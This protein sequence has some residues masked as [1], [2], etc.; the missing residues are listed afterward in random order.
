VPLKELDRLLFGRERDPEDEP[1]GIYRQCIVG[2]CGDVPAK[3]LSAVNAAASVLLASAVESR[4][5]DAGIVA[6]MD[7][8]HPW[9]SRSILVDEA[10]NVHKH[11]RST[12]E[13]VPILDIL[14]HAV[15]EQG[16]EKI[17]IVGLP[18]QIQ[19]I[20]KMQQLGRPDGL[21]KAVALTI[22]T[23]CS[24]K[25]YYAGVEHW[26]K[27]IVGISD[28]QRIMALHY[29]PDRGALAVTTTDG[30]TQVYPSRGHGYGAFFRTRD[31]CEVCVDFAGDLA[32][33]SVGN[34]PQL[35]GTD[36]PGWF[37]A[38]VRTELGEDTVEDAVQRHL[39]H[40]QT[41]EPTRPASGSCSWE[42]SRH[43]HAA[44]LEERAGYGWPVP[45]FGYRFRT[46]AMPRFSQHTQK[47]SSSR[48]SS[49]AATRDKP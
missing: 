23:F 8:E 19:A 39:L 3:R 31:R 27:E 41:H 24:G 10:L 38:L 12:K 18:C 35:G 2:Y 5:I 49:D 4:A 34:A 28:V 46:T 30:K 11:L 6:S 20:R 29:W 15:V 14:H 44:V 25:A 1:L 47:W 45:M 36:K 21:A 26:L 37:T 7:G 22:G 9:R 40:V 43:H 13:V 17:G 33:I 32:D 42:V 16:N 48:P